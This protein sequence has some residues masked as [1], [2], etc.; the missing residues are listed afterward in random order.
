MSCSPHPLVSALLAAS[1]LAAS[2][3]GGSDSARRADPDPLGQQHA[4]PALKLLLPRLGGGELAIQD[5]RGAPVL[6]TLFTTWSLRCQAEAP[7]LAA[8]PERYPG[9]QVVGVALGPLGAR[10]LP[11][12]EAFVEVSGVTYPVLLAETEDLDLVGA[13]GPVRHV[14]R[15]LLLDREGKTVLEQTGQTDFPALHRELKKLFTKRSGS[16]PQSGP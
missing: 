1:L 11:M 16:V 5:L 3:C 8:L 2:A 15:T 14:P 9:L 10:G 7:L 13:L 12:V 6:L 4:T